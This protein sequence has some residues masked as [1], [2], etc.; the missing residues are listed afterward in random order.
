MSPD[1]AVS[2]VVRALHGDR[3]ALAGVIAKRDPDEAVRVALAAV[4]LAGA[5]A[6]QFP[7][8]AEAVAFAA[9]IVDSRAAG[10]AA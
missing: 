9:E 6:D 8:R 7:N 1:E 2:V 5:L 3:S 10:E 4:A